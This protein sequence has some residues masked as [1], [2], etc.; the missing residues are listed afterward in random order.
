MPSY[1]S[2]APDKNIRRRLAP[3]LNSGRQNTVALY[4]TSVC[5]VLIVSQHTRH[6]TSLSRNQTSATGTG[7]SAR[8]QNKESII[9]LLDRHLCLLVIGCAA[10][11]SFLWPA[12]LL[13]NFI[14]YVEITLPNSKFDM[15]CLNHFAMLMS[16]WESLTAEKGLFTICLLRFFD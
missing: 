6:P 16:F 8:W 5:V 7:Y 15:V 14:R 10:E 4:L 2:A 11:P 12:W 1:P 3:W 13:S 9:L